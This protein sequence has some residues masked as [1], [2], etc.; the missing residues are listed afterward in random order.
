MMKVT[1][2]KS[3]RGRWHVR[4]GFGVQSFILECVYTQKEA[5]WFARMLRKCLRN[6]ELSITNKK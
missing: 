6:Y 2:E 1:V 3:A 5:I 4:F